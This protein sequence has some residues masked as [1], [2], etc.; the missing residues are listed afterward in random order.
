M[1]SERDRTH[2]Q[3]LAP[4]LNPFVVPNCIDVSQYQNLPKDPDLR[5]DVVFIGKMDYRPNVD[6]MLWF[7]DKIWPKIVAERPRATFAIVGQKPHPRLRTLQ[8][9]P[10]VTVTGRVPRVQPYLAGAGVYAMPFR[11]GSGTRLKLIE[12]LAAGKAVVSTTI[13][14]EGY[15]VVDGEHLLLTD[16]PE[17][18]AAAVLHLLSRAEERQ[19]LGRRGRRLAEEYD[20][21][22][23]VPR[24]NELY[25]RL[26]P[27]QARGITRRS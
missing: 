1:V 16:N 12:A 22:R 23:V 26:I 2:L 4:G 17:G 24:F 9:L 11:I 7:G 21:R 5:F 27:A 14:A 10:G 8:Q 6:A 15:P 18:F 25:S 3:R 20:W 19:A 13:G